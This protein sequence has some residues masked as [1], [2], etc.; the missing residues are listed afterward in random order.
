LVHDAE[1]IT[2]L[3]E[4]ATTVDA[5]RGAMARGS[6]VEITLPQGVHHALFRCL[7]PKAP[8]G[9]PESVDAHG[10][11]ELLQRVA[12]VAG[13]EE[14]VRLEWPS[15]RSHYQIELS[16]PDPLLVLMPPRSTSLPKD[17]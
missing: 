11:P 17:A 1:I 13:L 7:N 4:G 9:A 3:W 16:S 2:L 10:G 8:P 12:A 15:R 6:R 14:L 5:A